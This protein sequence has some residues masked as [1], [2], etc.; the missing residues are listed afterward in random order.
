MSENAQFKLEQF[1][2]IYR[3][4]SQFESI[5]LFMRKMPTMVIYGWKG[6]VRLAHLMVNVGWQHNSSR[7]FTAFKSKYNCVRTVNN[8]S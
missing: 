7:H 2:L 5:Y 3:Q 6:L 4:T 8:L 1:I